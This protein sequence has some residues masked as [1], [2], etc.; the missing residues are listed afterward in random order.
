MRPS[1]CL[2]VRGLSASMLLA[3]TGLAQAVPARTPIALCPTAIA[4]REV[5]HDE[6]E[7][8]IH[9]SPTAFAVRDGVL[10][11]AGKYSA[12]FGRT[13]R[14]EFDLTSRDSI[15][16]LLRLAN[17]DIRTFARPPLG[18]WE[19]DD[20]LAAPLD[21][22]DWGLLITTV[23]DTSRNAAS[24]RGP[25]WF[26]RLSARGAQPAQRVALPPGVVPNGHAFGDVAWASGRV[27]F[28]LT[29]SDKDGNN[30]VLLLEPRGPR[31]T[32]RLLETNGVSSVAVGFDGVKGDL[33]LAV[34]QP[35]TT[36]RVDYNSLFLMR[37]DRPRHVAELLATGGSQPIYE[38]A[39]ASTSTG[40]MVGWHRKAL[41]TGSPGLYASYVSLVD[42]RPIRAPLA[43][44]DSATR[45]FAVGD[46][47]H[48][49]H[50]VLARAASADSS[51]LDIFAPTR[52]DTPLR[53]RVATAGAGA[54][55]ALQD[56]N[57]I[58][59]SQPRVLG[60]GSHLASELLWISTRCAAPE[61]G[62]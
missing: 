6:R 43:I 56:G 11:L 46:N 17:G 22:D 34:I 30:R 45:V 41:R 62:Q 1:F 2:L 8:P 31:W 23:R 57:R 44:G 28:A 52:H 18:M 9:V 27:V 25:V 13:A 24:V 36:K 39:V 35:D 59:V 42:D 53:V 50:V 37:P 58:V 29:A 16:A 54:L 21:G 61:G 26:M 32:S 48:P 10:L 19:V 47:G 5:L 40:V 4:H 55:R 51:E 7:Q 49:A 15:I 12:T 3:N 33:A 14:A 20:V 60:G 38:P